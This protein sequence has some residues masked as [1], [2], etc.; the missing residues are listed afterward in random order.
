MNSKVAHM[1][2]GD[3]VS[4]GS[5]TKV[6]MEEFNKNLIQLV[7]QKKHPAK[8]LSPSQSKRD[9]TFAKFSISRVPALGPMKTIDRIKTDTLL[10][11]SKLS[12]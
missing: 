1:V 9:V 8:T 6:A 4:S 10:Q 7:N 3:Y 2:S 12:F 5:V 11:D